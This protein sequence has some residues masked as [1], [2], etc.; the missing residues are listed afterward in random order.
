[1]SLVHILIVVLVVLLIFSAPGWP[2]TANWGYYPPAASA[3]C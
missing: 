1:M 2:H 3:W